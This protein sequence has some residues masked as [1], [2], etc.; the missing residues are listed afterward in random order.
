MRITGG[1]T[2]TPSL[3]ALLKE[4]IPLRFAPTVENAKRRSQIERAFRDAKFVPNTAKVTGLDSVTAKSLGQL[5]RGHRENPNGPVLI[6]VTGNLNAAR[7]SYNSESTNYKTVLEQGTKEIATIQTK[8]NQIN[9][10]NISKGDKT[11]LISPEN[12]KIGVVNGKIATAK[13]SSDEKKIVY[14]SR[15]AQARQSGLTI[16]KFTDSAGYKESFTSDHMASGAA[17]LR[18]ISITPSQ[19]QRAFGV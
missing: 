11:K 14:D 6:D 5:Q 7:S 15:L 17:A 8:I 18:N 4:Y 12:T 16:E 1:S 10:R 13:S 2:I 3:T 19:V 9:A